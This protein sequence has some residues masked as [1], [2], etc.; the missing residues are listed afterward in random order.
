[1]KTLWLKV[2]DYNKRCINKCGI[3]EI[4]WCRTEV[5]E[6][7]PEYYQSLLNNFDLNC[8]CAGLDSVNK[9]IIYTAQF[10]E[11]LCDKIEVTSTLTPLNTAI[12]SNNKTKDLKTNSLLKHEFLNP[13]KP[14]SRE[15]GMVM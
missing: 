10:I 4:G 2:R 1:M 5:I 7:T 9:K 3:P 13:H 14:H 11:F 12:R 8:C 6:L 15:I